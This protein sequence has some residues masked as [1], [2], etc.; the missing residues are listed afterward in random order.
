MPP[1]K[2][3]EYIEPEYYE[4]TIQQTV[5]HGFRSRKQ[6]TESIRWICVPYFAIGAT[7]NTVEKSIDQPPPSIFLKSG[8]VLQGKYFQVAELWCIVIGDGTHFCPHCVMPLT[9]SR[10]SLH[11][12][13]E[14]NSRSPRKLGQCTNTTAK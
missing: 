2:K 14:I 1:D 10:I 12:C 8:Y 5:Y 4:E 13:Q 11:L 9:I 3:G 7:P 6:K